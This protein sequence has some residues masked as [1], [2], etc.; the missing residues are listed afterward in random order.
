[1]QEVTYNRSSSYAVNDT[2][3][4]QGSLV[5]QS[6]KTKGRTYEQQKG[7]VMDVKGL[8]TEINN[9][10]TNNGVYV[11]QIMLFHA[12]TTLADK[13][14]FVQSANRKMKDLYGMDFNSASLSR[15]TRA[16]MNIGLIKLVPSSNDARQKEIVLTTKGHQFKQ[17]LN[18][19]GLK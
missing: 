2:R 11:H 17:T 12:I 10:D 1:M 6:T 4:I 9:L 13:D 18:K 3:P 14:L 16:L 19:G 15:N 8:L 5:F 7:S